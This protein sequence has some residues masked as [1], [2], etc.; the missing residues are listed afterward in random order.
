MLLFAAQSRGARSLS[1]FLSIFFS[2]LVF[3][4]EMRRREH[5]PGP[6]GLDTGPA[7]QLWTRCTR[8]PLYFFIG[9]LSCFS[10]AEQLDLTKGRQTR[11]YWRICGM[12]SPILWTRFGPGETST[13]FEGC[14][15]AYVL[16]FK[17]LQVNNPL[18][19]VRGDNVAR[20]PHGRLKGNFCFAER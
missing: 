4:S 6:R 5:P 7:C 10:S 8:P 9:P 2:I 17:R 11:S 14:G 3:S 1:F 13:A 19:L 12:P 18:D 20:R 16:F 15:R